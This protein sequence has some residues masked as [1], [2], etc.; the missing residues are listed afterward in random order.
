MGM[1][2]DKAQARW[3]RMEAR[4]N[5]TME[6]ISERMD[7]SAARRKAVHRQIDRNLRSITKRL[8]ALIAFV[9]RPASTS[10]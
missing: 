1:K 3:D 7:A 8:D 6:E 5:K 9:S 4:L 2:M 10:R